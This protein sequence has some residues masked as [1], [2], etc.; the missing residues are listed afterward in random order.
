M[1]LLRFFEQPRFLRVLGYCKKSWSEGMKS[2]LHM[3]LLEITIKSR[4]KYQGKTSRVS[5][6]VNSF[7]AD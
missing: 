1:H 6:L 2:V 3:A 5:T 7:F 4:T